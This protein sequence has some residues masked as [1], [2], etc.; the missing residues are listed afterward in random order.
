[1]MMSLSTIDRS[2]YGFVQTLDQLNNRKQ[3]KLYH[4]LYH[5]MAQ[6]QEQEAE[7]QNNNNQ[8]H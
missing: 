1:M 2:E 7:Q 8:L 4:I 3:I 5:I 6:Q